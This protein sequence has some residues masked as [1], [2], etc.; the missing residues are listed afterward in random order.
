MTYPIALRVQGRRVVVV[1]AGKVAERRIETL[2]GA[3]ADVLVIAPQA[4][5]RIAELA[6]QGDI[7]W[8][9]RTFERGDLSGAWLVHAATDDADVNAE[10]DAE[11][12]ALRIW[13]VRADDAAASAAWVPATTRVGD[14]AVSVTSDGDPR[15]SI[16]IRNAIGDLLARGALPT[17]RA[18]SSG[19]HVVLIGGGP[20]DP[21]LITVRGLA[22]LRQA[23]VV[24]HDRL[25][26]GELLDS[27][28]ADV[29]IIDA[30]KGPDDHTLTQD[31]IN[32]A[33]VTHAHAGRR[34]ARLKGG[35]PF[36]LGRGSE[37]VLACVAAGI[38]VDV[39]PGISSALSAPLA[40]GIPVTHRGTSTGFTVLSGH[41][42]GDLSS[43]VSSGLTLVVLMGVASLPQLIEGLLLHGLDPQTPVAIIERAHTRSQRTT[44]ST[45]ESIVEQARTAEVRNPAVIVVGDVVGIA[46]TPHVGT[47]P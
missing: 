3:A 40:A 45:V 11:A 36:V 1:G 8:H 13:S 47:T 17:R 20:G 7:T 37:E 42:I 4:T 16:A 27:L 30:G 25:S 26:P 32:K 44:V 38:R 15:R 18:R 41:V 24:I 14:V 29:V 31:E 19:G 12:D 35:D 33:I 34:V 43:V 21:E 28:D 9:P 2:L 10:V 22:A 6:A 46:T 39:V 5:P 23:D